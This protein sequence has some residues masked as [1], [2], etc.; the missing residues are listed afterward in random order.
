MQ[1]QQSLQGLAMLM[2]VQCQMK[3]ELVWRLVPEGPRTLSDRERPLLPLLPPWV[4]ALHTREDTETPM[5]GNPQWLCPH[6]STGW[7]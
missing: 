6:W 7:N 3:L 4:M 2:L 5:T 1:A